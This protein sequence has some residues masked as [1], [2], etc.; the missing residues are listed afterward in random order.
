[1][2][3]LFIEQLIFPVSLNLLVAYIHNLD[4][5]RVYL[6][7][8]H[9]IVVMHIMIHPSIA[10]ILVNDCSRLNKHFY[11]SELLC[12]S[13][14]VHWMITSLWILLY[15][16]SSNVTVVIEGIKVTKTKILVSSGNFDK[17]NEKCHRTRKIRLTAQLRATRFWIRK[18]R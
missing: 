13:V 4:I 11:F 6:L 14:H 15:V 7:I 8:I 9:I 3:N 16:N 2:L 18:K 17:Q 12:D 10:C 5:H 1:M